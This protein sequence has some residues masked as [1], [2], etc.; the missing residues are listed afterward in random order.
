MLVRSH[1]VRKRC[2][3][4]QQ[5]ALL[6]EFFT[7]DFVA[8]PV[9]EISD[10]EERRERRHPFFGSHFVFGGKSNASFDIL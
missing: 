6:T 9:G 2:Q 8:K 10:I 5:P 3:S 1:P 4:S 7:P